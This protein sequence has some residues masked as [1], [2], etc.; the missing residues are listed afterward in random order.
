M[1]ELGGSDYGTYA[2][3]PRVLWRSDDHVHWSAVAAFDAPIGEIRLLPGARVLAVFTEDGQQFDSEDYG[4]H[5]QRA[6]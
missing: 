1:T 6:R 4:R 5:W 3:N 2:D